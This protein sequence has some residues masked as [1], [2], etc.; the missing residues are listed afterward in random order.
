MPEKQKINK[1]PTT[2]RSLPELEV[3]AAAPSWL[4]YERQFLN[5]FPKSERINAYLTP[6]ARSLGNS[7]TVY[8]ERIDKQYDAD[9]N[10]FVARMIMLDR[11]NE[12]FTDKEKQI[13][14]TSRYAGKSQQYAYNN[15]IKLPVASEDPYLNFLYQHDYLTKIPGVRNVIQHLAEKKISNR[16]IEDGYYSP[17]GKSSD[18]QAL[19]NDPMDYKKNKVNMLSE[20]LH[21]DQGLNKST[22]KPKQDYLPF[23]PTYSLKQKLGVS[24]NFAENMR[25]YTGDMEAIKKSP[26]FLNGL[27]TA[28]YA[29]QPDLGHYKSGVAW[30]NS[31]QLPYYFVSDAWDFDPQDYSSRYGKDPQQAYQQA[32]LM[33][34]IGNPFKVYDRFYF[35][36]ENGSYIDDDGKA[37]K[38][39]Q[40][41]GM[42]RAKKKQPPKATLGYDLQSINTG[43]RGDPAALENPIPTSPFKPIQQGPQPASPSS[44]FNIPRMNISLAP[45]MLGLSALVNNSA[46]RA[47]RLDG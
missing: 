3:T 30:D 9:K 5:T 19:D 15:P 42:V 11:N 18:Q 17:A 34:E 38:K 33:H 16:T 41:G 36:P 26:L 27:G 7:K 25:Q 10:D 45:A 44:S 8:P 40:K 37:P 28:P 20:Y 39:M 23:L 29:N 4:K 43:F 13:I 24:E 1:K 22:S 12:N 31:K 21:G 32:F 14:G 6:M 2:S 35:N 46:D 47:N